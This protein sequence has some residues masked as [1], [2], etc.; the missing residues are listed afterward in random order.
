M[1]NTTPYSSNGG[2]VRQDL[3]SVGLGNVHHVHHVQVLDSDVWGSLSSPVATPHAVNELIYRE[4]CVEFYSTLSHVIPSSKRKG[5]YVEFM[6]GGHHHVLTY[7]RF[8]Q[9]M[10]LHP[11][12]MTMTERQ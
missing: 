6:L 4:L 11:T 10:R 8:T 2:T 1:R 12:H 5:P 3:T 9:A 7:D